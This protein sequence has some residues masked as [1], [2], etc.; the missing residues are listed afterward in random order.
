MATSCEDM[1]SHR[2]WIMEKR[3]KFQIVYAGPKTFVKIP[4][5]TS[6]EA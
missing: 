5:L 4:Q 3:G 2:E 1:A 6:Q